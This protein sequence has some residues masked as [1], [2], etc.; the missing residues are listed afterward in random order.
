VRPQQNDR[1]FLSGY[2][3]VDVA[4]SNLLEQGHK[5]LKPVIKKYYF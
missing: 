4:I 5:L 1:S 3:V 2:F